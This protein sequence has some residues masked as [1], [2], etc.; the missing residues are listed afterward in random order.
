MKQ[1]ALLIADLLLEQHNGLIRLAPV[2]STIH[3]V[4][5]AVRAVTGV[6]L[7]QTYLQ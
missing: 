3:F 6:L 2:P 5:F 4:R 7:H 1:L